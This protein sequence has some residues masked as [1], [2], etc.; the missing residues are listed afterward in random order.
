M[1]DNKQWYHDNKDRI[2]E[3]ARK[4]R[5]A[6]PD[7][8]IG[9]RHKF[10]ETHPNRKDSHYENNRRIRWRNTVVAILGGKC[11]LCGFDNSL[12]LEID[13][14]H[15][16]GKEDRGPANKGGT[17][18]EYR[19]YALDPNILDKLACLCSNCHSIKTRTRGRGFGPG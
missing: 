16:N 10:E 15:G 11:E 18:T 8:V 9:Y 1:F 4:W 13:H 7:K 5:A 6:N 14:R 12:A 17:A 19:R 2:N 3:K